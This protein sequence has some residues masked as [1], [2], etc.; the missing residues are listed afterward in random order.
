MTAREKPACPA[1][2]CRPA[3]S[4]SSRTSFTRRLGSPAFSSGVAYTRKR[5]AVR[6]QLVDIDDAQPRRAERARSG[7]ERQ[8]RVVLVIDRVV[9]PPLDQ[10]EQVRELERHETGVLDQRAESRGETADVG[11]V[12]EDVVGDDQVGVSVLGGDRGPGFRA[13]ELDDRRDAA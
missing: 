12:R 8:V 2:V 3:R 13:E 11:D 1:S 9:L 4:S 10:A 7:E 5:A 6:R